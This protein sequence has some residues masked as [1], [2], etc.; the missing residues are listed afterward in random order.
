VWSQSWN[1]Q[2]RMGAPPDKYAAV[3][4]FPLL[5]WLNTAYSDG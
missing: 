5:N 2:Y 4:L 3:P 1:R